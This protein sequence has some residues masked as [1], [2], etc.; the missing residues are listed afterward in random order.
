MRNF[1]TGIITTVVV[2][3]I[4]MVINIICNRNGL[5]LDT[6]V[7]S[8]CAAVGA[9]LVYSGLKKKNTNQ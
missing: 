1:I 2:V 9:M 5:Q 4:V 6:T 7:T 3:G 8:T